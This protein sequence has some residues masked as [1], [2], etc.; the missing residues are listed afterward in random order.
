MLK[1][2]STK[3]MI[4]GSGTPFLHLRQSKKV[5]GGSWLVSS[6]VNGSKSKN[7]TLSFCYCG[8][9]TVVQIARTQKNPRRSFY[10]CHVPK[11]LL[12]SIMLE[13][14][15]WTVFSVMCNCFSKFICN[16]MREIVTVLFGLM[17]LIK[18]L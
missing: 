9:R 8:R 10:A 5:T 17:K 12:N 4:M 14:L 2:N 13:G 18:Y 15:C 3:V 11:V 6:R 1:N 16:I 7:C